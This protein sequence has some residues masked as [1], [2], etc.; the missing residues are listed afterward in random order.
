MSE[1]LASLGTS[2]MTTVVQLQ[3]FK[4]AETHKWRAELLESLDTAI[5]PSV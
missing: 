5:L 3:V 2:A 4:L 1:N